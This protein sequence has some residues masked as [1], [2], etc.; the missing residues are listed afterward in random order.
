MK[1]FLLAMIVTL[2]AAQ[3]VPAAAQTVRNSSSTR[4]GNVDRDGTLRNASGSR[5]GKVESDGTVRDA[6][7]SRMGSAQGV[8]RKIAAVLFFMDLL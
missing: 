8:D 4:I 3:A 2:L 1:K 5:L 7:G 6:S